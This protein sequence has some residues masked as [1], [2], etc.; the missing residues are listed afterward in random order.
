MEIQC[1]NCGYDGSDL[2]IGRTPI[3]ERMMCSKCRRY[4]FPFKK[5]LKLNIKVAEQ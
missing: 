3:S 2:K 4:F 1:P 5:S